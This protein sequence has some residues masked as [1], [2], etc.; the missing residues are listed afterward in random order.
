LPLGDIKALDN[1]MID[2]KIPADII[3][4]FKAFYID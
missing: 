3:G 2:A 1:L 4:L